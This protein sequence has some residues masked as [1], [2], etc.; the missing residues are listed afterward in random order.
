MEQTLTRTTR[1]ARGTLSV[2]SLERSPESHF[3]VS[4]RRGRSSHPRRLD[5]ISVGAQRQTPRH[6][7]HDSTHP[8]HSGFRFEDQLLIN[9]GLSQPL[10]GCRGHMA[11]PRHKSIDTHGWGHA[12][13]VSCR[14][15]TNRRYESAM[16]QRMWLPLVIFTV[17]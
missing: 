14:A 13:I 16:L 3:K 12:R 15:D 4:H 9:R 8:H 2:T 11:S 1:S 7:P 17:K 5:I 6:L 10:R